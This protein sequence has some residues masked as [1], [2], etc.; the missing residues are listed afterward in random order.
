[1]LVVLIG[2]VV[3]GGEQQR[4]V[5]VARNNLSPGTRITEADVATISVALDDSADFVATSMDEVVGSVLLGPVGQFE[6]VQRSNVIAPDDAEA[7]SGLAEVS[8]PVDPAR[9]PA[10]LQAGQLISILATGTT[11]GKADTWPVAERIIVNAYEQ[12]SDFANDPVLR[13]AVDDGGLVTV[14]THAAAT[15]ELTIIDVTSS[16]DLDLVSAP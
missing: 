14:I 8:I 12:R 3:V 7:P 11:E 10:Q 16:P 15:A 9:A 13:L 6:F 5:I 4:E 2:G 1:M